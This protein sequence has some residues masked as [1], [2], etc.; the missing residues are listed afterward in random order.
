LKEPQRQ[1]EKT[2]SF[3]FKK[4]PQEGLIKKNKEIE[5]QK[6]RW[7]RSGTLYLLQGTADSAP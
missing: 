2:A 5:M 1:K 4:N 3:A 6:S 7:I